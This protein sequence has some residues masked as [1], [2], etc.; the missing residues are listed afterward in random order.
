MNPEA[1]SQKAGEPAWLAYRRRQVGTFA[2][3]DIFIFATH[4]PGR[5][6]KQDVRRSMNSKNVMSGVGGRNIRYQRRT[7]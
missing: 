6:A 5:D 1:Y 4:R 2:I 3:G 7:R